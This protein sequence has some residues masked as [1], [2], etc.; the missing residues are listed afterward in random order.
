MKWVKYMETLIWY[1]ENIVIQ[2]FQMLPCM[3]AALLIWALIRPLRLHRLAARGL[4]S[5][6][7][8]EIALL[9]YVLFCVGLCALTLFPYGFWGDC[10]RML[11]EP[12]FEWSPDFPGWQEGLRRLQALPGSITPFQ[13]ILRVTKG[14]PWLE[15]VLWGNIAIFAPIGFGLG[16]LWREKRWYHAVVLGGVFSSTIEFVQIF[17]G[18]VSDVDDIM[19]NTAGTILGFFFYYIA[20]KVFPFNWNKFHCQRKE[21]A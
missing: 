5:P 16:L 3:M 12:D 17:V 7:R 15:F 8:R 19:L 2:G 13:E 4:V 18:R 21:A 1:I 20:C 14:G 11:W 6:R 9:L 10:I